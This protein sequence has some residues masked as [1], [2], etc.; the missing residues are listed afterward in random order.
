MSTMTPE[1]L[2]IGDLTV[3]RLG[4]GAMRLP[5]PH[6]WGEPA[7]PG[8]AKRVLRRIVELGINLIDTS[9]YYGPY[10]AD[11]LIVEALHPYPKDLVIVTKLGGK[12]LPDKSWAA[13]S[14][15]EELK[16]AHDA[17]LKALKLDHVDLCHFRYIEQDGVT[18]DESL[19][20]M[21]ELQRAGKI[22]HLGLSNVSLEQYERAKKKMTI[23]SVQNLFSAVHQGER[24]QQT[25]GPRQEE[26]PDAVLKACER[27]G[28]PF[29][30]FF[31]LA[32]GAL[33][34]PNP[35]VEHIAKRHGATPA[36]IAIAWLL[37][38]SRVMLP[39]PGTSSVKHLEENW[40]AREITLTKEEFDKY[41]AA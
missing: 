12:R 8:N 35:T 34:K 4:Y 29:M 40:A 1:T 31:P 17:E 37:Q 23:A 26:S 28:V 22:R 10:V 32:M 5:G 30:P 36:Q 41:A 2:K 14:K 25:W 11:R 7:D 20:A 21:V 38:R 33:G 19:D 6:V 18:F 39:I 3:K 16:S 15:P 24:R 13:A 27:D 9:W